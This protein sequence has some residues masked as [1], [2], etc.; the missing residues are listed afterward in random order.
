MKI[1]VLL[2]VNIVL[3]LCGYGF[4]RS[5]D[6]RQLHNLANTVILKEAEH[7]TFDASRFSG[8]CATFLLLTNGNKKIKDT[9]KTAIDIK[10]K[11]EEAA[12]EES[13]SNQP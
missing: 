8:M 3:W 6:K 2:I 4:A 5:Y 9:V 11:R 1:A 12:D 10:V 13:N 7:G